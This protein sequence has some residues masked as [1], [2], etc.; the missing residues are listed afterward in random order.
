M[1]QAE[2]KSNEMVKLA[3]SIGFMAY[4]ENSS[5]YRHFHWFLPDSDAAGDHEFSLSQYKDGSV[6]YRVKEIGDFGHGTSYVPEVR[7]R[8]ERIGK[9][10]KGQ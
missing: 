1:T 5:N 3:E 7:E 4:A 2:L 9:R 6:S 8:L 10:V